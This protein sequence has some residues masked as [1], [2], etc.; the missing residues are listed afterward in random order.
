LQAMPVGINFNP[1]GLGKQ[2]HYTLEY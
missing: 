1:P 2:D